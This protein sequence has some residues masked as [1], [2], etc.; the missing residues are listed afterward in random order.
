MKKYKISEQ[1][2]AQLREPVALYNSYHA[3]FQSPLAIAMKAAMGLR[4]RAL[5]DLEFL[6]G[7]SKQAVA[8]FLHVT[9]RSLN[10]YLEEDRV[11][12][13]AKSE[14]LLKLIALYR[15]GTDVFGSKETFNQWLGAPAMGIGNLIP[16][17]LMETSSGID[18]IDEE[19]DR[20]AF[21][22]VL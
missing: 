5:N 15:K 8:R 22:D 20:I 18:I 13:A 4:S 14:T 17:D 3:D 19:L 7:L 2:P 10:R 12:D 16:F 6:S 1:P 11:L 21:G 9:S